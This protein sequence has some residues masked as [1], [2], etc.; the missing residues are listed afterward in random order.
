METS[1]QE[2]E[3]IL[4]S[5]N[6]KKYEYFIK[7]TADYEEVWSLKDEEGWASLEK[8]EQV[9]FPVWAKK[10][11]ADLC[12]SDEWAGYQSEAID[13][14]EFIEDWISGLKS[15]GIRITVMWSEGA[16]IDVEWD[17]LADDMENEL[18]NY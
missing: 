7:K 16:G 15:D 10:E 2:I 14:Y 18:D 13:I 8:D 17:R 12:V 6:A 1:N 5:D 11:Y 9:F 4:K 3:N